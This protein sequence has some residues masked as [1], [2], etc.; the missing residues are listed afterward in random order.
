MARIYVR[1]K[2]PGKGWRYK[3]IPEG[4]GRRP[5][6]DSEAKF[7]VRY[8]DAT[9]KF[10]YSQGYDTLEEAQRAAKELPT[11]VRAAAAGLTV[12]EYRDRENAHRIPIK[13]RSTTSS[14]MP[15]RRRS[16]R[17]SL[18]TNS[19]WGS[20]WNRSTRRLI[21]WTKSA[22]RS[23]TP[24]AIFWQGRGMRQERSTTGCSPSCL[25]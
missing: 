10:V 25:C 20:S 2:E 7:H 18:A 4:A 1:R 23:C 19:T 24:S 14:R 16:R 22:S 9:G 17:R 13:R 6:F 21:S 8:P 5:V 3:A 11:L 12:E 15:R